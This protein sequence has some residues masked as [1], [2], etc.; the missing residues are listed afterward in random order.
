M[1]IGTRG[2]RKAICL[3]QLSIADRLELIGVIDVA[4]S[5]YYLPFG[6]LK[7]EK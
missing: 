1:V 3:G 2:A 7:G 6:P 5:G 4:H